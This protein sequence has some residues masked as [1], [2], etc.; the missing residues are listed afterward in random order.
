NSEGVKEHSQH[1]AVAAEAQFDG[2]HLGHESTLERDGLVSIEGAQRLVANAGPEG[3]ALLDKWRGQF[4]TKFA[5]AMSALASAGYAAQREFS[6]LPDSELPSMLERMASYAERENLQPRFFAEPRPG[7]RTIASVNAEIDSLMNLMHTNPSE[8]TSE[9]VQT[10]LRRLFVE[11]DGDGP[12]VGRS[13]RH[14][15]GR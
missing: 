11:R 15:H 13:F 2:A 10:R 5:M 14:V 8:Y 3:E 6:E 9:R 1:A 7:V 12:L 4:E